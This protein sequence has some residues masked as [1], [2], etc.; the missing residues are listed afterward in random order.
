MGRILNMNINNIEW[1]LDELVLALIFKENRPKQNCLH[2]SKM[3]II[4]IT[5]LGK[6]K[7]AY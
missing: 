2:T 6:R 3:N 4:S 7:R 1:D 5:N